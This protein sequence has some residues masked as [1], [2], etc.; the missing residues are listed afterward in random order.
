MGNASFQLRLRRLPRTTSY[1]SHHGGTV[2]LSLEMGSSRSEMLFS[3]DRP[4]ALV[5]QRSALR[6][7][8]HIPFTGI[9]QLFILEVTLLHRFTP[10]FLSVFFPC[11]T[12][13]FFRVCIS[14]FTGTCNNLKLGV[15]HK[16][17][18][19]FL[20]I[21]WNHLLIF[22]HC[23]V[24]ILGGSYSFFILSSRSIF[25]V[26]CQVSFSPLAAISKRVLF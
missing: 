20:L 6:Q 19:Y 14:T 15:D 17:S 22:K 2:I 5:L 18:K 26:L 13:I 24:T 21:K 25:L 8:A 9:Q 12:S 7:P 4:S 11:V 3:R 16:G 10:R 23:S 1:A